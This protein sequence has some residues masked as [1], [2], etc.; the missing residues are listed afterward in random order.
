MVRFKRIIM[1]RYALKKVEEQAG[2]TRTRELN[3]NK[4]KSNSR[5]R[6]RES[7]EFSLIAQTSLRY[8]IN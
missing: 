6:L 1:V 5:R 7:V 4:L 2:A 8:F 3:F